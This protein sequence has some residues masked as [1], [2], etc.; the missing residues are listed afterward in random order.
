MIKGAICSK[1]K[2]NYP[3]KHRSIFVNH[4]TIGFG[5]PR[6]DTCSTCDEF[7]AKAKAL[8]VNLKNASELE[9]G[10]IENEIKKL[11]TEN[12]LHKLKANVFYKRKR[13]TRIQCPSSS[14]KEATRIAIDFITR[15][16][17]FVF[18]D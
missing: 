11:E 15:S 5:Y 1:T 12:K 3:T 16:R 10:D 18:G 4:F 13:E 17:I 14:R 2:I 6:S 8:T 9:K 7:L